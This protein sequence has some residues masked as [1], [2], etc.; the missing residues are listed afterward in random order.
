MRDKFRIDSHKL[1]YHVERVSSWLK[2]QTIFPLYIEISP[3]G[4]CNHRCLFCSVDFMGFKKRFLDTDLLKKQI[5]HMGH[6]KVKSIM[7]AGEGEPFLH[8]DLP[9]I[10]EHTKKSGIDVA[11]TTNGSLMKSD[12]SK[13]IIPVTEWIKVSLNA[14][15]ASTYATIHRTGEKEFDKVLS[16]ITNAVK[17]RQMTN[18]K[19][20]IGAQM[21]L[22]EE[23]A[24]EIE[25][26]TKRLK[27]IGVDY[28]VIKPYTHHFRNEH[29][30]HIQYEK[31][32]LISEILERYNSDDFQ[33]IFRSNA[34]KKWDQQQRSYDHC[35]ALP[36][37]SYIDAAGNVWGCSAH[38]LE[39]KFCYGS[40]NHQTFQEIWTGEKRAKSLEWVKKNL[41]LQTCKLNCRMDEVNMYLHELKNL[42]DHVNFI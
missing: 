9:Q 16:N 30:Y 7:F 39:D 42:P 20:T 13:K 17:I 26:L 28:L 38:L 11:I 21:L 5:R 6:L 25:I 34:M 8:K 19:C 33:V 10:I 18:S 15:T 32:D 40:I 2:G 35:R 27:S 12:I 37:W 24:D 4:T 1:I 22:I 14:G 3:S 36:F 31:F 29:E 41:D 23:N